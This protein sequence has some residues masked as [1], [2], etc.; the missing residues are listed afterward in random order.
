MV[1]AEKTVGP[2]TPKKDPLLVP[3]V[4]KSYRSIGVLEYWS[5]VKPITPILQYSNDSL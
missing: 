1:R 5:I 4:A 3:V 2:R